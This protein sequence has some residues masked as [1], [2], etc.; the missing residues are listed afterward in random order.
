MG[1]ETL[2]SIVAA[3]RNVVDISFFNHDPLELDALAREKNV[4]AITDCGVAP[5]MSNLVAGF[6]NANMQV[7]NFDCMVGGLPLQRDWPYE[8]KAPFS[9]IDVIE[10][11]VRPAR[12]RQDGKILVRPALSDPELID[13]EPVGQLEAFNTDGLRTL[14]DTT[15]IPNMRE[16]TLRYPGH[17][18]LMRVFRESGFF[19][20]S[21]IEVK[22]T[23]IRPR[24]VTAALLFPLWQAGPGE[25]AFTVMA[26]E[27]SGIENGRPVC[28][29]YHLYDEDDAAT[30]LSSMARTTGF[31]ATA[32]ARLV[33]DGSYTKPGI[34]PPEKV[35]ACGDCLQKILGLLAERGVQYSHQTL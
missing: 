12:L 3:G 17:I 35:G 26:I 29:K 21:E 18:E 11:Y 30:G 2:K 27:V 31:T 7:E 13:I 9:P 19:D 6:H 22:G 8:Y 1:F 4:I 34:S 32:A 16:R 15:E 23:R 14:L 25:T 33:L 24:D 20:D 10:E 5:G 28:H